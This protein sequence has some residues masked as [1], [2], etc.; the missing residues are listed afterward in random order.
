LVL[1]PESVVFIAGDAFPCSCDVII[2]NIDSCEEL[3]EWNEG[4]RSGSRECFER[5]PSGQP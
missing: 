3:N 5:H 1:L 2:A 4:R